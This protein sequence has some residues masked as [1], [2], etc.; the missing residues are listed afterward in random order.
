MDGW[1]DG[2]MLNV[3]DKGVP[4]PRKL[5]EPQRGDKTFSAAENF[6]QHVSIRAILTMRSPHKKGQKPEALR[7]YHTMKV[8]SSSHLD[9]LE[10]DDE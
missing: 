4:D 5:S 6:S 9:L 8:L 10:W 2:W 3:P 1:M 7:Y